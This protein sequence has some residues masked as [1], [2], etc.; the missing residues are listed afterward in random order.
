MLIMCSSQHRTSLIGQDKRGVAAL[1]FA[2]IFPFL[3]SILMGVYDIT[4]LMIAWERLSSASNMTVE[5]ATNF[6]AQPD[7]TNVLTS[8]QAWEA[9]TAIY[10]YMPALKTGGNYSVTL[11]S[12]V[13]TPTPAFCTTN[14]QY[15]ATTAWSVPLTQGNN[16][17]RPCGVL[18]SASANPNANLLSTL[19]SGIYGP[20]ALMVADISYVYT[21]AF[22][23]IFTGPITLHRSA[24]QPPRTGSPSQYVK[25]TPA[26][27]SHVCSGYQ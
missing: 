12:V 3:I 9:T 18:I 16:V 20:S 4:N 2:L 21:P 22:L 13:M 7:T 17:T 14:C 11:T 15:I 6:A 24:Y 1:E 23:S 26:G 25:Y 10:A 5:I 19:P 8:T 27:D